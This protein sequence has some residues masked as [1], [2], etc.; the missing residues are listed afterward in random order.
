VRQYGATVEDVDWCRTDLKACLGWLEK[1]GY[2]RVA[3]VG[4]SLGGVKGIYYQCK[5]S[6][7]RVVA[8]VSLSSPRL[9][10]T[11]LSE[12]E[13]GNEFLAYYEQADALVKD[14]RPGTLMDV[15]FPVDHLF[16]AANFIGKMGPKEK[17]DVMTLVEDLQVPLL[18]LSGSRER[19]AHLRDVAPHLAEAAI[20]SPQKEAHIIEGANHFYKG[21]L[22]ETS[23]LILRWL[24]DLKPLPAE[25]A[26]DVVDVEEAQA[27][28]AG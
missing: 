16:S 10:Y 26:V 15:K 20:N 17:Y 11:F 13:S 23:D 27:Q 9:S 12:S 2:S 18:A 25:V 28:P 14:R 22:D 4:H 5:A 6:D 1:Q 24:N 8:V 19:R 3:L 21:K 7:P